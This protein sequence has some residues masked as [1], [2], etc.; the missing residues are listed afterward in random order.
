MSSIQD[1]LQKTNFLY[2]LIPF[3]NQVFVIILCH[4]HLCAFWIEVIRKGKNKT[5]KEP[6]KITLKINFDVGGGGLPINM[7]VMRY[8]KGSNDILNTIVLNYSKSADQANIVFK[9]YYIYINSK[10]VENKYEFWSLNFET[11][12]CFENVWVVLRKEK[13]STNY[14]IWI[15]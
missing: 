8:R 9:A 15:Q 6:Y 3:Y 12:K 10:A 7:S 14:L 11:W 13:P 1:G 5:N 2:L 4:F